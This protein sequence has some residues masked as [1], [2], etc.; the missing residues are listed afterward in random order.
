MRAKISIRKRRR[1]PALGLA[2]L[3]AWFAF[4]PE[5]SAQT[6]SDSKFDWIIRGGTLVDGSAA[7][8]YVGDLAIQG[9]RIVKLGDLSAATAENEIDAQ[10]LIV[11]PGFINMLS[12]ATESLLVDGR[13]QSDLRQGV[14]LEIF[15]E[16]VSMG[17]LNESMR[18][19]MIASQGDLKFEVPWTTLAEYLDHLEARGVSPNV[20][21]FVGA[22][23]LRIHEIGYA[24]RPPTREE[25]RRM[26]ALA[27]HEMD[28]GALGIGSSLIYAPAF[29]AQAPELI[30]LAKVAAEY[31]GMYISHLRSE[32]NRLL[33]GVDEFLRI[34]R[35]SGAA[36]EIYHLKAAGENNWPKLEQVIDKVD[37][38]RA[39]GLRISADM[40]PYTAGATGLDAAMPPWVQ[41][42]GTRKWIERLRE[43]KI[44]QRVREEM[45]RPTDEWENLLLAA[46]D[47]E[48]VLLVGFKNESLKHL[49][50][51][52][53]AEIARTRGVSP[54]DAAIDLVIQDG[55][56]VDTV[57][58]LM[59]E[60]S[61]ATKLRLPWM[62]ICSD[63]GSLAP[64]GVFR[65][66]QP[67]PRAYGS[68]ARVLG[69]Y[70]RDQ[71]ALT[72]AEAI[73]RMTGWPAANL[74]LSDRGALREECYADVVVFDPRTIQDHAT[75]EDP[76]RYA[77]GVTQVFVNGTQVIKDGEHTGALPGRAVRKS[78]KRR[79]G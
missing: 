30:E 48:R 63:S 71:R 56:R 24:D 26:R 44:R 36:A 5:L 75:Y 74:G 55:S 2:T 10:G 51:K 52:S 64:E 79:A 65:E 54:E 47:P 22:T 28:A 39:E 41:E 27:R 40:Y 37:A 58:F 33:E 38:A 77:T 67:H 7:E 53:L 35:E 31:D 18:R 50:G 68:F 72:L 21:S 49:T 61:I 32:G 14:T 66:S 25:M 42:G 4:A 73:H 70:V 6:N 69:K 13:S 45:R 29:Y 20:A 60:P 59:D 3:L 17:P 43:P 16:G 1:R 23:T 62:S 76:H 46:G 19:D 8:P 34:A 15:G 57:Y 78:G 9:D 11:A 12:W